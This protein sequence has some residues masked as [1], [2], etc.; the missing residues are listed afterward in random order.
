MPRA[1]AII[2]DS[3][4]T[5]QDLAD[6]AGIDPATVRVIYPGL[7]HPFSP[8]PEA[9]DAI[10]HGLGLPNGPLVLHVGQV[11]FY[12]NVA[13]CLRVVARLRREGLPVTFVRGG[14]R[15]TRQ[16]LALAEQLGVSEAVTELGPLS[17]DQLADL[18]RAC[19]VL[20]FPSLYEGFGWPPLEAM[21]SGLPVVCSQAGSL[22]EV[23]AG[24][25]LTAEAEDVAALADHVAAVL[26]RDD[27]ATRLRELGIERASQ[28]DWR[29]TGVEVADVYRQVLG[30]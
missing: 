2:A 16:Q 15:M 3:H 22:G 26:T 5:R 12:K 28:F 7:N 17:A 4:R 21:A 13:G 10:R 24:A 25:A 23:V 6:L 20:L 14:H 19:D 30:A 1:K 18:Y 9:R 29:R 11:G 8:S 27:V